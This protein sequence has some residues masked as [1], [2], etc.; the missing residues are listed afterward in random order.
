MKHGTIWGDELRAGLADY[1]PHFRYC[2]DFGG[3][4]TTQI[5]KQEQTPPAYA[6]PG[7]TFGAGEAQR[8]YN[9][10]NAQPFPNARF[11]PFNPATTS[12]LGGQEALATNNI[13]NGNPLISGAQGL[14]QNTLAGNFL[15]PDSNP[16]MRGAVDYA[17]QPVIDAF[18]QNVIPGIDSRFSQ[19]GRY[20][21]GAHT[22]ANTQAV[23][24]LTRNLAGNSA[25][26]YGNFYN[27]ER[28]AQQA[29]MAAAPGLS[30]AGYQDFGRLAQVGAA[31]EG[32]ANEELQG[33]MSL[34]DQQQNLPWSNLQRMV[35]TIGGGA[36]G[37]TT[38][39][40]IP[41]TSNPLLS[42][43]GAAGSAATT[44][45]QLLAAFR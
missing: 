31:R 7:L 14:A 39:S 15:S 37:G 25:Q 5:A 4:S 36:P 33:A 24:A 21:S 8:L 18:N 17:N 42:G 16:W 32:K 23:D 13:N 2:H 1:D 9:Q 22:Q 43:I 3:E 27:Q 44:L 11:V 19:S 6:I 45:A 12:A 41:M 28:G 34:W 26:M 40:H 20:G 38:T 30:D 35:A 29:A 10:G